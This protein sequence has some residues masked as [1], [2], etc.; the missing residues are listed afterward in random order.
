MKNNWFKKRLRG[1][2][3]FTLAEVL[4][5]VAI[6]LIL[7]VAGT[8]GI[9]S[10]M[11]GLK[12]LD[13]DNASRELFLA[14][15]NRLANEA[16]HGTWE[17]YINSDAFKTSTADLTAFP[18][19][20]EKGAATHY[21]VHRAGDPVT[22]TLDYLLPFGAIDDS[23][24]TGGSYIIT[25]NAASAHII[26]VF[27]SSSGHLIDGYE[28]SGSV[29]SIGAQ[30]NAAKD[31]DTAK[32]QRKHFPSKEDG[33]SVI[34]WYGGAAGAASTQLSTPE[35]KVLNEEILQVVVTTAK[36]TIEGSGVFPNIRLIVTG[37]S[38][39]AT[40]TI[41]LFDSSLPGDG[42]GEGVRK[43][44]D[45]TDSRSYA[46]TLDDIS[47]KGSRFREQFEGFLP[48]ENITITAEVFYNGALTSIEQDTRTVSSLFGS[49]TVITGRSGDTEI[50]RAVISNIRHLQN[51]DSKVS[52]INDTFSKLQ[53]RAAVQT[54]D[55]DWSDY[56]GYSNAGASVSGGKVCYDASLTEAELNAGFKPI[57]LS[58][59]FE[60]TGN[61]R[62]IIGLPI[63]AIDG[64]DAGL[65]GTV[66]RDLT[67]S[68]VGLLYDAD[69]DGGRVTASGAAAGGL[70]GAVTGGELNVSNC[71]S[72]YYIQD[73]TSTY[74]GGLIGSI[75]GTA[76]GSVE[77]SYV[78][79][80]T[81]DGAFDGGFDNNIQ[82]GTVGGLLGQLSANVTVRYCYSTASVSGTSTAGGLIGEFTAGD[83]TSCFAVSNA[84]SSAGIGTITEADKDTMKKPT[85]HPF[86]PSLTS[87]FP[88]QTV[89]ELSGNAGSSNEHY[90]DWLVS[91]VTLQ[92][93]EI[94]NDVSRYSTSDPTFIPNKLREQGESF[95]LH[96]T[97]PV[98][99]TTYSFSDFAKLEGP[100]DH[101][102]TFSSRRYNITD[103]LNEDAA[104]EFSLYE[105]NSEIDKLFLTRSFSVKIN[106]TE[107]DLGFVDSA[108][109]T[110]PAPTPGTKGIVIEITVTNT[111]GDP[112]TVTYQYR[113]YDTGNMVLYQTI[114]TDTRGVG[115][116][117]VPPS[118]AH[119]HMFNG[120][121]F[122]KT[123]LLTDDQGNPVY[124][125]ANGTYVYTDSLG[126]HYTGVSIDGAGKYT[127]T[128]PYTGS[129]D[130]LAEIRINENDYYC[131]IDGNLL[132][133]PGGAVTA[134]GVQYTIHQRPTSVAV[135]NYALY[136]T[137]DYIKLPV[138]TVDYVMREK[139][140]TYST[141]HSDEYYQ[142]EMGAAFHATVKMGD[143]LNEKYN[144]KEVRKET[145]AGV[146]SA[147]TDAAIDKDEANNTVTF[148]VAS[149]TK[150]LHYQIIVESTDKAEYNV[151]YQFE[152]STG[153]TPETLT[154]SA[155]TPYQ[156]ITMQ[157]TEGIIGLFE[158]IQ[159]PPS[160][161]G[162]EN[163]RW[164]SIIQIRDDDKDGKADEDIVVTYDRRSFRLNYDLSGGKYNGN[165]YIVDLVNK[166]VSAP[167]AL[168]G[169]PTKNGYDF[170]GWYVTWSDGGTTKELG[171]GSNSAAV[172]D[173][174]GT[175][176][177]PARTVYNGGATFTMPAG[178]ATA[179]AVWTAKGTYSF[180]VEYYVENTTGTDYE[181]H[182]FATGTAAMNTTAAALITQNNYAGSVPNG[183]S[184]SSFRTDLFPYVNYNAYRTTTENQG[185]KVTPD[186]SAV[187]RVYFAR[188]QYTLTFQDQFRDYTY[189]ETTNNEPT[190]Q[191]ALIDGAYVELTRGEGTS[192]TKYYT[193]YTYTETTRTTNG[194]YYYI[195]NDNLQFE[196][197]YLYRNNGGWYRTRSGR[198]P[199]YTYSNAYTGKVFDRS[200]GA[201]YEGTV[202]TYG[203][204]TTYTPND[205]TGNNLFA[206]MNGGYV[207]L[208]KQTETQ[209]VWYIPGSTG[210]TYVVDNT[211]GTYGLVGGEYVPLTGSTSYT[212]NR[213]G[214]TYTKDTANGNVTRY[215]VVNGQLVQL[216]R[217]GNSWYYG[218][219]RYYGDRYSRA[220][221][222]NAAYTG[223]L[224]QLI[225][226]TAG[227]GESGFETAT[228]V[229]GD[230]LFG[231]DGNAYFQLQA[232]ETSHYTLS[233][234]TPYAG[235]RYSRADVYTGTR[236]TRSQSQTTGWHTVF[237]ITGRY[238][239]DVS[240]IFPIQ[241]WKGSDYTVYDQGERWK[242][243]NSSTYSQVLVF[244][245]SMPHESIT[246]RL[247]ESSNNPL[248]MRYYLEALP[249]EQTSQT[250]NVNGLFYNPYK[251][252]SAKYGFITESEDFF[253]IYGFTK[254]H[255]NPAFS[256]GRINGN[257]SFYYTRH[258]FA[259]QYNTTKNRYYARNNTVFT[260]Q[261]TAANGEQIYYQ[262]SIFQY[263]PSVE[264]VNANKSLFI[265]TDSPLIDSDYIFEGWYTSSGY[266]ENTRITAETVLT[267]PDHE[268]QVFAH[269][270]APEKTVT[271]MSTADPSA[272]TISW[273]VATG[274]TDTAGNALSNPLTVTKKDTREINAALDALLDAVEN[275]T[276]TVSIGGGSATY[277]FD[278]WYYDAAFDRPFYPNDPIL[279]ENNTNN[280]TL[281]PK[282]KQIGGVQEVKVYLLAPSTNG[283][284]QYFQV[285]DNGT[286][287]TVNNE[288]TFSATPDY[289]VVYKL[290]GSPI[291]LTAP[292]MNGYIPVN[293]TATV[294]GD[295]NEIRFTYQ[296]VATWP[297]TVQ[298]VLNSPNVV[299]GSV[300]K[301]T[302]YAQ[303]VETAPD[304]DGFRLTGNGM[305]AITETGTLTF[306][307]DLDTSYQFHFIGDYQ[308]ASRDYGSA[309]CNG[310]QHNVYLKEKIDNT[311]PPNVTV[312]VGY[313]DA[314]GAWLATTAPTRPGSYKATFVLKVGEQTLP[315]TRTTLDLD[316]RPWTYTV[317][318]VLADDATVTLRA[319]DTFTES[320]EIQV[321]PL[322]YPTIE[323]Y[324]PGAAS[325]TAHASDLDRTYRLLYTPDPAYDY[326]D[327]PGHYE[328]VG[329]GNRYVFANGVDGE[330]HE[331]DEVTGTVT[332][333]GVGHG[334]TLKLPAAAPDG[335]AVETTYYRL[336]E[337]A[338]HNIVETPLEEGALPTAAGTY[339]A[340]VA[341]KLNGTTV[342]WEK[343]ITLII[344]A[345]EP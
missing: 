271:V 237:S 151:I 243:Q 309:A 170:A 14:A 261:N 46:F 126:N 290:L 305:Q 94:I 227:S 336:T 239:Q 310:A 215:G 206:P 65:F 238:Q 304:F 327:E 332:Q 10:Y 185:V 40:R 283:T 217:S 166:D 83:V 260:A 291:T 112:V 102:T 15:E 168:A 256:G 129:A 187:I 188:K 115:G 137:A 7:A 154:Y 213:T 61:N 105:L 90:G 28:F 328:S 75:S 295:A 244:I 342:L 92:I 161:N 76:S 79:G 124:Q 171:G 199:N 184:P 78:G 231:K 64:G 21:I 284:E 228:A 214:Y 298:Y 279:G 195:I 326:L 306:Y 12:L 55:L 343:A 121:T 207:P 257:A 164:S 262:D 73:G 86:D 307:Y 317:Q 278:C 318:Y 25:Y 80:H 122:T 230:G 66:S 138:I 119:V 234:G 16:A 322:S 42:L 313:Q 1:R 100:V 223:D 67:V 2:K 233:D 99:S 263:L 165:S 269:W 4:I 97:D 24:R 139:D 212:Y 210:S 334:V 3:G 190:P 276:V 162:F 236:Y 48:G 179:K 43:V 117:V 251:T 57:E 116:T 108:A 163:P 249:S 221:S 292:V 45:G 323:G 27:Y 34:G 218:G 224:Y 204:G 82:G 101:K 128:T 20:F 127:Y 219:N 104:T 316:V 111:Y 50:A 132:T 91:R 93:T 53:I 282:Y 273:T 88:Y 110:V 203:G 241:G 226:G 293:N 198:W 315:F 191:Y 311:L 245:A 205:G 197:V 11:R 146:W 225:N 169:T 60:Y 153:T 32:E 148:S 320:S 333:D 89:W 143:K 287:V 135:D 252:I 85:A 96:R 6:V 324:I 109:F 49:K 145:A 201:L 155:T 5:V 264:Y 186:G 183:F 174:D 72:T 321:G 232:T 63:K 172:T 341:V 281:Y 297:Y 74:T 303:V 319:A 208:T 242:P 280:T 308:F 173:A 285:Y 294:D 181:Y 339:K 272:A 156:S 312:T 58:G 22:G 8:I 180:R 160:Y 301:H 131:D 240:S 36:E 33:N 38:S 107:T 340:V 189:T 77:T 118:N 9:A 259:I 265:P 250:V 140:D 130:A 30:L 71:F 141:V 247:D 44:V 235:D 157:T 51:L 134:A 114:E 248:T 255:S 125:L 59:T 193:E 335:A 182:G 266:A 26:D 159:P 133:G 123:W 106:G 196:R 211:N 296:K 314:D 13:L 17:T 192:V 152:H 149:V 216:T 299:L 47:A 142:V 31:P 222:T 254:H 176:V 35:L 286:P 274:L 178:T 268:L 18:S 56:T 147:T 69:K 103:L 41:V 325:V 19:G 167:V 136:F 246:F 84:V 62:K 177:Y 258:K 302:S 344:K 158:S 120:Y 337:D 87:E 220:T 229:S 331:T 345:P 175:T 144:A 150:D 81:K 29:D 330:G 95:V 200:N 209:Y 98:G 270:V 338:G 300:T 113:N 70:I 275:R 23:V 253:D 194:D 289:Y 39:E 329:D 288:P 68:G 37:N 52:G 54:A 277:E 267:M 202:Y